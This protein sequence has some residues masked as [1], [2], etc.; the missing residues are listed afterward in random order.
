MTPKILN[1]RQPLG[2]L[3]PGANGDGEPTADG[4][5]YFPSTVANGRL[6]LQKYWF[7]FAVG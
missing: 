2:S 6:Q 4:E 3:H 1:Y 5:Q 7:S